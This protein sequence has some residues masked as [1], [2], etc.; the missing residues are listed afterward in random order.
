MVYKRQRYRKTQIITAKEYSH[1]EG[2]TVKCWVRGFT[3]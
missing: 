3:L 2:A 1:L